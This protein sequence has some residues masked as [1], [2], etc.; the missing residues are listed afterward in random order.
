MSNLKKKRFLLYLV[1]FLFWFAQYV[2][3]PYMTPYL[4]TL[5]ISASFAG[6][7]V[8]MYGSTQL[9]CRLP[10]GIAADHVQK[11]KVFI[12]LGLLLC[13]T[14]SFV[15][16]LSQDPYVLLTANAISGIASSMWISFTILNSMYYQP[17]ELSQSIGSINAVNNAGILCAYI[18]GGLFYQ[19]YGMVLMFWMSMIAGL[20]GAVVSLFIVDEPPKQGALSIPKLLTVLKQKRL[21]VYS[22]LATLFQFIVFATANS[23]SNTVIKD[24]GVNS[25]QLSICSALFTLA[26]MLSSY[27][28]GTKKAAKIGEVRLSVICFCLLGIYCL[29]LPRLTTFPG[30]ALMQFVGGCG[31]TSVFSMIMS[32]AIRDVPG[33]Q[34]STA[35]GFF[36]SVYSIGIMTGPTVMGSFIDWFTVVPSFSII[37]VLCIFT[38]A[39]Y[40]LIRMFV[41]G[42]KGKLAV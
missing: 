19:K 10:L 4:L 8:G 28:V 41:E 38:A 27:F 29:V 16:I 12:L 22:L 32:S 14:A 37:G 1:T 9:L 33:E 18:L 36:Q 35:M 26:G 15:R 39:A 30:M 23:F 24:I 3:N 17:H 31:G 6:M 25:V 7:I 40:P 20:L 34:R 21:I 13:G 11:H 42:K 5:N 2:Y